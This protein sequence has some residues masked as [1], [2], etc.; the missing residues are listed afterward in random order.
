MFSSL[1]YNVSK[2]IWKNIV[3]AIKASIKSDAQESFNSIDGFILQSVNAF[4]RKRN[5]RGF[6][7]LL[8][9][10]ERYYI[11]ASSE[12]KNNETSQEILNRC[13]KRLSEIMFLP[14]YDF[15][16]AADNE[17]EEINVY[18][19]QIFRSFNRIFYE[20]VKNKDLIYF[21]R[22]I[23]QLDLTFLGEN[24]DLFPLSEMLADAST[25]EIGR[26]F[27][28]DNKGKI[29]YNQILLGIRYWIY[30]L[31]EKGEIEIELMESFLEQLRKTKKINTFFWEIEY[32]ISELNSFKGLALFDWNSWDYQ[33][34]KDGKMR[35]LPSVINWIIKGYIVDSLRSKH[36]LSDID[37]SSEIIYDH[38]QNK[39]LIISL[40]QQ[41][42]HKIKFNA[43]WVKYLGE[44]DE[45]NIKM[46]LERLQSPLLNKK[47]REIAGAELDKELVEKFKKKALATWKKNQTVRTIFS[48][49]GKKKKYLWKKLRS[50]HKQ[51]YFEN[52]K[53]LFIE[54][55]HQISIGGSEDF[56]RQMNIDEE[57]DF[58]KLVFE[59]KIPIVYKSLSE[60][61]EDSIKKIKDFE[62]NAILIDYNLLYVN[63]F[64]N[65]LKESESFPIYYFG[66]IPVFTIKSNS[67]SNSFIAANFQ[68][69]FIMLYQTNVKIHGEE[70]LSVEVN[71]VPEEVVKEKLMMIHNYN[72]TEQDK[73][74]LVKSSVV[75]DFEVL[76]DF[77]T[78]NLK[79][80]EIGYIEDL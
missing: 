69:A 44:I 74:N 1:N 66:N 62:V 52:G 21:K 63:G 15:E 59:S 3:K 71:E 56:V 42:I 9:L 65:L 14:N 31:Y 41:E 33:E 36:N 64:K 23:E 51:I 38:P 78:K 5:L 27:L 47:A 61:I 75:F 16:K 26:K 29:F 2:E 12:N 7:E 60:G 77:R 49:F 45:V 37:F 67:F 43:K 53:R 76:S 55:E 34:I 79:A 6:I 40:M 24:P 50:H 19:Y 8:Q 54:G 11:V 35:E 22:N 46:Q 72:M 17:K 18:K 30:F 13:S 28:V 25:V 73:R 4:F 68:E 48:H 39:E 70:E 10:V 20:T 80:F 58:I 57:A 32:L